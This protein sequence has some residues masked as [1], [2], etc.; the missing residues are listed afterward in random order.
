M[1]IAS[2]D[3]KLEIKKPSRTFEC[4][5]TIGNNIYNNDDIVDIILDNIQAKDGFSIGNTTSQSLDLT[6]INK[7]DFIYSTSTVKVEIGLKIG[8]TIEYILM[9]YFNIDDIEKTDYTTKV[10]CYDNMIKFE[11]PYFSNL[12]YP[13]TLQQIVNE[14]ATKTGVQFTGSLPAYTVKKLEGFTCREILGYIASLC[15]GNA[16]ITREGKFTIVYLKEINYSITGDNY[17]DYKREEIKYK[18]GKVSCKAEDKEISKGALGT[19]SME[20][21]FE[22]PWV[23]ENILNDIYNKL[24][25]LSY[26]GYTMKWQ[27]D[28]SLDVGD[29][30]SCTD[31]KGVARKIPIL[32]QKFTYNG[33]LTSEIGAKGETKNKN[34]FNSSG[35]NSNK[36]DRVVT[37]LL[38]VNEALIDK[39]NIQDLEAVNIKTQKLE[40]KTAEI[41]NAIIGKADIEALD[42]I[43]AN[44]ENLIATDA[45]INKAII[46]KANI[47]DLD[48]SIG[49]IT[50]LESKFGKID[51]LESDVA[52]IDTLVN[53]HLTTDNMQSLIITSDKVTVENGFVKNAMID[54]MDVD[55]INAGIL[56]SDKVNI[57]SDNGGIEIVGATQQFKDRNNKVRIQMGQ[58]ALGNFNFILRGTDGTTTLIDHTGIKEKAIADNLIKENMISENAVKEKQ[59]DYSSFTTGFNKDTNTNTLKSSKILLDGTN[60]KLNIAFNNLNTQ[61]GEVSSK[62]NSNTTALNIQ[63]GKIETLISN[64]TIT[65]ENGEVVNLKDE[66]STTKNTVNE[67]SSKLGSMEQDI[68]N[69]GKRLTSTESSITQ[70][71]ESITSKVS[72][73]EVD[74]KIND[75]KIGGRNLVL[76]SKLDLTTTDYLIKELNIS[77]DFVE[78]KKYTFV[79]KGEITSGQ[80]FGLWMNNGSS[81][82]GYLSKGQS[83]I[84][85]IT[86]TGVK[87]NSGMEKSI[88]IYNYPKDLVNNPSSTVEWVAM[89]EG[90]IKPP[91]DWIPAPEDVD[92]AIDGVYDYVNT[93]TENITSNYQSAIEQKAESIV[94]SVSESYSTKDD[95]SSLETALKSLIE[96]TAED[97]T[98]KFDGANGYTTEIDGKLQEFIDKVETYIQFSSEGISLGKLNNP[99][100]ASLGNTELSFLQDGVKVAY[101]SNNKLYITDADIRNK[102]TIGNPTNGYFD[103]VPRQNGNLSMKW[104]SN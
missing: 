16:H 41:E 46:D 83:G 98:F 14:I 8:S 11:T 72:K 91:I 67:M 53:G 9:G 93:E 45:T 13:A 18:I 17:F 51:I 76:N 47:T 29:I 79:I 85:Y 7:G 6:L 64:T 42:V 78:G 73:T 39:A 84:E 77:I 55:K 57:K 3:Y 82:V 37:D 38:L 40:T 74:T 26:L 95:T 96:Q 58:D 104:R 90:E 60:Q 4:K 5:V 19:D 75:I 63:E 68:T 56:S 89:Y 20:L 94:S 65:K 35:S 44:I 10:T 2:E 25:G 99:F 61:V 32:S 48:A 54:N 59:I 103:Y 22:N 15:G 30:I 34:S 81:N 97:I 80:R 101:I 21:Q 87:P 12:T 88:R 36:I 24:N 50:D 100:V 92:S 28:L 43:N 86:F 66:Y 71:N 49:R 31:V 52:K 69:V 102:L 27:G 33:G 70:L 62:T 23:N 1:Y